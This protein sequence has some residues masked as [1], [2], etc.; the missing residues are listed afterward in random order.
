MSTY[1]MIAHIHDS[2]YYTIAYIY[3]LYDSTSAQECTNRTLTRNMAPI[4]DTIG[5][6]KL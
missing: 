6:T 2:I 1:Y 3:D 5:G 4:W